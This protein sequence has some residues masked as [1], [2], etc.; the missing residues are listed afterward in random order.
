MTTGSS[1]AGMWPE[2]TIEQSRS[3][4]GP[5][6]LDGEETPDVAALILQEHAGLFPQVAE[7]GSLAAD[8]EALPEGEL[9]MRLHEVLHFLRDGLLPHAREEER[10]VY[11]AVEQV[12]HMEGGATRTMSIDHRFV[13]QMVEELDEIGRSRLVDSDR[14]EVRRLLYGLQT[15]L[16]VHFTKENEAY[17]PLLNSLSP[18]ARR[19]LHAQLTNREAGP[20]DQ[21][22]EA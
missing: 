18:A 16:T 1:F 21:A 14:E 10:S 8:S 20:H 17:V 13:G 9:R 6:G 4:V 11:P 3:L 12:L 22:K 2:M 19:L 5:D 15:L 7:L